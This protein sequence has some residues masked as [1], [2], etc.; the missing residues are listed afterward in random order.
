MVGA[1][2]GCKV[3][4]KVGKV[5]GVGRIGDKDG[6]GVGENNK[7]R[8]LTILFLVQYQECKVSWFLVNFLFHLYRLEK[9][10]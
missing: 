7:V 5:G 2:D 3:G 8:F 1:N 6:E 4:E 9:T 10:F